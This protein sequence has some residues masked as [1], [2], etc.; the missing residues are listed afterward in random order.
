MIYATVYF[1]IPLC[2]ESVPRATNIDVSYTILSYIVAD[3]HINPIIGCFRFSVVPRTLAA[4]ILD[5]SRLDY[6]VLQPIQI[7]A[8]MSF[9]TEFRRG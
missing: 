1:W 4:N 7:V 6:F 8:S 5:G 9:R 2:Y 3:K